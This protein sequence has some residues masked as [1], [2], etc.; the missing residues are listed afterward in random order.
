MRRRFPWTAL[1]ALLA[2]LISATAVGV[3]TEKMGDTP[4]PLGVCV[5][6]DPY[7]FGTDG[8]GPYAAVRSVTAPV[9]R[10]GVI[11]CP[12]GQFVPV[13]AK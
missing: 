6:T 11:T 3:A 10:D 13:Q 4:A 7:A 9:R 12:E 8:G 2:L 1:A 5:V